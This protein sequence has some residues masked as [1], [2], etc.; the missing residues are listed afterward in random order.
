MVWPHSL[1]TGVGEQL[2]YYER[3]LRCERVIWPQES[4]ESFCRLD[5]LFPTAHMSYKLS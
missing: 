1:G 3:T 4:L 2:L 5:P